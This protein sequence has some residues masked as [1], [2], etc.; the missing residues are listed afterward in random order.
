MQYPGDTEA[1][2]TTY[3]YDDALGTK[4]YDTYDGGRTVEHYHAD[5]R[6]HMIEDFDADGRLVFLH[7]YY[8][9]DIQVPVKE[10]TS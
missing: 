7:R 10:G 6:L 1:G 4:S 2:R 3:T 8:Y 9:Q 5:G